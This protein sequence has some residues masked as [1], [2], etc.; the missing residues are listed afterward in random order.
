MHIHVAIN[1]CVLII[2]AQL[3][4]EPIHKKQPCTPRLVSISIHSL[5]NIL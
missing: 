1:Y 3:N 2:D 5:V 4:Y